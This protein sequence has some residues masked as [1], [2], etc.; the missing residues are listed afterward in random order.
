MSA[1]INHPIAGSEIIIRDLVDHSG[2]LIVA[3]ATYLVTTNVKFL[4]I[5]ATLT[6]AQAMSLALGRKTHDWLH[7]DEQT[8]E[9]WAGKFGEEPACLIR[10]HGLKIRAGFTLKSAD[11][12]P[13]ELTPTFNK[14]APEKSLWWRNPQGTQFFM[15][16]TPNYTYLALTAAPFDGRLMK[17]PLPNLYED[18]RICLGNSFTI[19]ESV[20]PHLDAERRLKRLMEAPWNTDLLPSPSKTAAVFRWGP[21]EGQIRVDADTTFRNSS[22][23]MQEKLVQ[24]IQTTQSDA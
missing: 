22:P 7:P 4:G 5:N 10:F 11:G 6:T 20:P 21:D 3:G 14:E 17:V 24:L 19:D 9:Y 13:F 12:Q 2:N 1:T 23:Y 18:G 8:A 15:L 16:C